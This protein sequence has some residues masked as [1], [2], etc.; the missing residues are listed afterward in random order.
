M[1]ASYQVSRSFLETAMSRMSPNE[2][3]DLMGETVVKTRWGNFV[4]LAKEGEETDYI[5]ESKMS[6]LLDLERGTRAYCAK[7]GSA[8]NR[9]DWR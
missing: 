7:I 4:V 8:N 2:K 6:M 3:L 5:Y 1:K 9:S